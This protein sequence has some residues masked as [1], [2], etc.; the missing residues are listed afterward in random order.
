MNRNAVLNTVE[1]LRGKRARR[2]LEELLRDEP[3][4]YELFNFLRKFDFLVDIY[5]PTTGE[6][7]IFSVVD[8]SRALKITM[9][10][11]KTKEYSTENVVEFLSD[12]LE[13]NFT[14]KLNRLKSL[15]TRKET[16]DNR[17]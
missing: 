2:E 13:I 7:V 10:G 5:N 8:G 14:G 11:F 9:P 1:T 3:D 17:V 15:F 12:V 4:Y 16:G 6:H